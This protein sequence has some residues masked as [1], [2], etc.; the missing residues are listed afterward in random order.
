MYYYYI[1]NKYLYKNVYILIDLIFNIK[2][3]LLQLFIIIFYFI[4]NISCLLIINIGNTDLSTI[5][6]L[7]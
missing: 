2:T 6:I 3:C 1:T 7:L 5:F 4:L